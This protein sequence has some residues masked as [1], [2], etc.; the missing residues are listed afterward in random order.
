MS[1]TLD[2]IILPKT[3]TDEFYSTW[4]TYYGEL[5]P[6]QNKP[7]CR[8]L[9]KVFS[10]DD[11]SITKSSPDL[12][13]SLSP[14]VHHL[15][16]SAPNNNRVGDNIDEFIRTNRNRLFKSSSTNDILKDCETEKS[17]GIFQFKSVKNAARSKPKIHSISNSSP[18]RKG[19]IPWHRRA[20]Q[21]KCKLPLTHVAIE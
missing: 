18:S 6:A 11:D 9:S 16:V 14:S 20:R 10:L 4:N 1:Q 8:P 2:H 15:N 3:V 19:R 17:S 13:K 5:F 21:F 12:V 7:R